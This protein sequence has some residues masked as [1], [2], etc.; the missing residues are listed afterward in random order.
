MSL[1]PSPHALRTSSPVLSS[2]LCRTHARFVANME[3]FIE[4]VKQFPVLWNTQLK[5]YHNLI[6][7]DVV[8]KQIVEEISNP[9]IPD[10]EF[11]YFLFQV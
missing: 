6:K 3:Q 2:V 9:D 1:P 4:V 7:K 11:N 5:D 10:G 8:W